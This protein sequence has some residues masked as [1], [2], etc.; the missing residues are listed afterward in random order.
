[1]NN[2]DKKMTRNKLRDYLYVECGLSS[3]QLLNVMSDILTNDEVNEITSQTKKEL[4]S[5]VLKVIP[6]ERKIENYG[7]DFEYNQCRKECI[8]RVEKLLK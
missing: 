5:E 1:M 6:K 8:E 7:E 2:L 4:V 3:E